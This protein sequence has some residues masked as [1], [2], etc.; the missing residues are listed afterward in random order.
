MDDVPPDKLR[1]YFQKL[2]GQ[3]RVS[4]LIRESCVFARQNLTKD[5]PFSKPDLISCRNVLIYLGTV[6]QQ[7]VLSIFHYALNPGGY[8]LLGTAE[9]VGRFGDFFTMVDRKNK[10]FRK[11]AVAPRLPVGITAPSKRS[12]AARGTHHPPAEIAP[13]GHLFREVDRILLSNYAPPGVLVNEELKILQFRGRTAPYLEPAPGS[14]VFDLLKMAKQGL[15]GELRKAVDQAR[16][17]GLRVG[18]TNARVDGNGEPRRV[19]VEVVPFA[20]P[21]KERFFLVLFA[22]L[23]AEEL[24]RQ[25]RGRK[26]SRKAKEPLRGGRQVERLRRE[27]EATRDYLQ[28]IIEEQEGTNEELR[29]ANEEI[30]S[31]NEELQSTNEELETAKEE[32]QSS[33]EELMTLNEELETR[34]AELNLVTNDLLNL[35]SS[36]DIPI[37]ML[38]GALRI[39][40][41]NNGAQR[42]LNLIPTDVGRPIQH[43]KLGLEVDDLEQMIR[44]VID[45]LETREIDVRDRSGR[46]YSIRIRPYKTVDN[47]I[48]GAVLAV[49]DIDVVK[50]AEAVHDQQR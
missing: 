39:R 14:A 23:P 5:P 46:W 33:N 30:Q 38:D 41:F 12:G 7:K 29:R 17:T 45:T 32:L 40:R 43:M 19:A 26:T 20:G 34:N 22:E 18:R 11:R 49:V 35:L 24:P 9:T 16:K 6:L 50:R 10:V 28:S 2:D 37:V 8:L 13:A 3:Y 47:R 27:L 15:L 42:S 31:S 36:V 21:G 1:R 25:K 48:E 44:S 4:E